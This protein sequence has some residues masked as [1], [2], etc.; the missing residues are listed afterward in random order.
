MNEVIS[1]FEA[2]SFFKNQGFGLLRVSV[3]A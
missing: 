2:L 3:R 1:I